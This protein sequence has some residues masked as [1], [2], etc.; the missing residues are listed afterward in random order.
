[1]NQCNKRTSPPNNCYSIE[2]ANFKFHYST[3]ELPTSVILKI[4]DQ[5][6]KMIFHNMEY[7]FHHV[8]HAFKI[9]DTCNHDT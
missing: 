1:M 7:P 8:E 3:V 6:A 4:L 2:S 9:N 5:L